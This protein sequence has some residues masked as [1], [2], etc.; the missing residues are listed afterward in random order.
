MRI[1]AY[2]VLIG[3]TMLAAA[4]QPAGPT[5]EPLVELPD[6]DRPVE[7]ATRPLPT[8]TIQSAFSML[9][10]PTSSST[11][12][13]PTATATAA[14]TATA[15]QT[16]VPT[17][18]AAVV[19]VTGAALPP[20]FSMFK[21]AAV[22]RPTG[23]TVDEQG[24]LFVTSQDGSIHVLEDLNGDHRADKDTTFSSGFN[25]PL[26]ISIS[27]D[28]SAVYVSS[29]SKISVLKDSDGDLTADVVADLTTG[30]PVGLHQ[31]DNLK[32]G[33]DGMLYMGIGSTCNACVEADSR[34]GT[35]MRFDPETGEGE[36]IATGLR[37]P[38]DLAFH[39][40]SGDLFA[41]DNGRDDLG[42]DSPFE[43]LNL[44]IEGR[45][46][47]WPDCWNAGE[48]TNCDQTETAVAFFEPHSSA[49]SLD[50]YTAAN[51]PEAYRSSGAEAVAYVA[52]FG[53]W[54]KPDAQTGIARVILSPDDD[55]YVSDVSWF[56][57]W[58]GA[59]PLG[60]VVSSDGAIFVGDYI[61]DTIYRISYGN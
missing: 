28:Q 44:I 48:G 34:S 42:M 9:S 50:F 59:M 21:Y 6:E 49:N 41:T 45:D 30:L 52:V 58:P 2:T 54:L 5:A 38:F 23:M 13:P 14:P 12:L 47:G 3:I 8:A 7:T 18:P 31:N 25:I 57:Q 10:E 29:S 51:F 61:N 17:V 32:F 16:P 4:C 37:N 15:T 20:G 24:R 22:F 19:E 46:Y 39:P 36:I 60:L 35:I 43:E 1:S 27:P 26:G 33:P 56:A 53:S 40:T 11:P 55:S